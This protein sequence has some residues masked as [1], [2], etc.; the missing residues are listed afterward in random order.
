MPVGRLT[1]ARLAATKLIS[2]TTTHGRFTV[3]CVPLL[4]V[5]VVPGRAVRLP[6]PAPDPGPAAAPAGAPSVA[7][8]PPQG[9]PGPGR[10]PRGGFLPPVLQRRR[11]RGAGPVVLPEGPH[12][13][14]HGSQLSVCR[15][16]GSINTF[17]NT[18]T[19]WLHD[20][21]EGGEVLRSFTQ[22][23]VLILHRENT[24]LQVQVL[25]CQ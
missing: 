4:Q 17:N 7:A 10:R 21:E 14:V 19:I 2:V 11:R 20:Q 8:G 18:S 6:Q 24:P 9:P 16:H 3:L 1:L 23:K 13:P 22:M 5:A 15:S 12:E 25:Q